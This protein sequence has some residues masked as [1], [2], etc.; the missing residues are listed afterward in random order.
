M[1]SSL[2]SLIDVVFI[3]LF[4]FML[5]SS[6]NH[7]NAIALNAPANGG[8]ASA[9]ATGALLVNVRVDGVRVAGQHL[10]KR[11]LVARVKK[12]RNDNPALKVLVHPGAG[13]TL[14]QTVT[15]LDTLKMAGVSNLRLM[16][17]PK[18][19]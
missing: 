12:L 2:T 14:Q 8:N 13:V 7:N 19:S 5:A 10:S 1:T 3:L 9:T 17:Q 15:V 16:G 18:G 11:G 6:F 4:F